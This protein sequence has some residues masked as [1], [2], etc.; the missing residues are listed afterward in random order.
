M[1]GPAEESLPHWSCRARK[2]GHLGLS[3]HISQ[4]L[5]HW[6]PWSLKALQLDCSLGFPDFSSPRGSF[7]FLGWGWERGRVS[8]WALPLALGPAGRLPNP[9]QLSRV[10]L[11]G[12]KGEAGDCGRLTRLPRLGTLTPSAPL[13]Q[14]Q[15]G[16][17]GGL[18]TGEP[19]LSL[20]GHLR[21]CSVSIGS[22]AVGR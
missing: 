9:W 8:C 4:R 17:T 3:F 22:G 13:Q 6:T 12:Q 11:R 20:P 19:T 7:Q 5:G 1:A 2:L 16:H 14:Q 15:Q 10:D 18:W 21:S